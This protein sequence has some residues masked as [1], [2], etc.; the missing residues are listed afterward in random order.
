MEATFVYDI[1]FSCK[2]QVCVQF[3]YLHTLTTWH[4]PHSPAAATGIDRYLVPAG[5]P[6]AANPQHRPDGTERH[7]DARQL[8]RPRSAY[9]VSILVGGVA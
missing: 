3:S 7:T 2:K 8:H 9:A 5:G 4:C 1:C 6:T